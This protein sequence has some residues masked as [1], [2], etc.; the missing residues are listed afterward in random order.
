MMQLGGL[1][2]AEVIMLRSE[3]K[4]M[5]VDIEEVYKIIGELYFQIHINRRD[6]NRQFEQLI[7]ANH[8]LQKRLEELEGSKDEP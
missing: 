1:K 8:K 7:E 6:T 3:R 5:E 2:Q 4:I